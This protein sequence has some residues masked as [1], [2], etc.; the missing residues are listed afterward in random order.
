M[1]IIDLKPKNIEVPLNLKLSAN[2][3][4]LSLIQKELNDKHKEKPGDPIRSPGQNG[5]P[6]ED[7]KIDK[8]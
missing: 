4:I 8:G 1:A 7:R 3:D 6:D 2:I 5:C